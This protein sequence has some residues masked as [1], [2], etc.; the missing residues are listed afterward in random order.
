MFYNPEHSFH[1]FS[2]WNM[3]IQCQ[4]RLETGFLR[5]FARVGLVAA[6]VG[7]GT[8]KFIGSSNNDPGHSCGKYYRRRIPRT[9][10][11]VENLGCL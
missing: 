2:K 9:E 5:L 8:S 6:G 3:W 1:N 11:V 10:V 4:M 7:V